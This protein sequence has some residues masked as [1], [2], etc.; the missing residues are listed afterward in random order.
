MMD[1]ISDEGYTEFA[2]FSGKV[3]HV[4]RAYAV[5]VADRATVFDN[6]FASGMLQA[7]PEFKHLIRIGQDLE[8]IGGVDACAS[9]IEVR[10]MG[11]DVY[12]LPC[13]LGGCIE[14]TFN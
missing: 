4:I 2:L 7:A 9:L 5:L 8:N 6:C 13:T 12:A 11:K 1:G 14:G 3:R 10:E